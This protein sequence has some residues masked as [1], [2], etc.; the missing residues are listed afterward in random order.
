MSVVTVCFLTDF[1]SNRAGTPD[2]VFYDNVN[3]FTLFEAIALFIFIKGIKIAPKYQSFIIN[4]SKLSLGIYIIRP[5][6]MVIFLDLW[7]FDS[8]F[9]NPVYFI[10]IYALIVF[11]ISYCVSFVLIK[12]PIIKKFMT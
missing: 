1:V 8:A 11:L 4:S 9:L 7:K 6:V 10:P 12:I 5:L 2:M 3:V